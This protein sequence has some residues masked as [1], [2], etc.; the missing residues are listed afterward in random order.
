MDM[1]INIKL[2]KKLRT[3]KSWTQ[4]QL[5]MIAGVSLRTIQRLENKGTTSLETLKAIAVVFG[6]DAS[7][8]NK[9]QDVSAISDGQTNK[10]LTRITNGTQ[11]SSVLDGSLAFRINHDDPETAE[12]ADFLAEALSTIEDWGQLLSSLDSGEKVKASFSLSTLIK[13]IELHGFCVF[14]LKTVEKMELYNV[15]K[16]PVANISIVR[17]HSDKIIKVEGSNQ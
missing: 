17:I 3:E 10:F 12:T 13:K 11:L 16:W 1:K 15:D 14:G 7:Q 9:E 4:D 6:M 5:A 2:I 8:L